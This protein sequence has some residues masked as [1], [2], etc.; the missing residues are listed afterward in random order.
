MMTLMAGSEFH[1]RIVQYIHRIIHY[2]M[3]RGGLS[4]IVSES[5]CNCYQQNHADGIV[6]DIMILSNQRRTHSIT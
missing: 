6:T 3:S 2:V 4:M 1:T 5:W